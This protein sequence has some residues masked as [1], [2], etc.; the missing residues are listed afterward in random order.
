M[1]SASYIISSLIFVVV[2][3][4]EL[5]PDLL[6]FLDVG[7]VFVGVGDLF[8]FVRLLAR[9]FTV[10]LVFCFTVSFYPVVQRQSFTLVWLGWF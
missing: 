3:C 2:L 7:L 9:L 5:I 8:C 10:F 1:Y 6:G 4:I